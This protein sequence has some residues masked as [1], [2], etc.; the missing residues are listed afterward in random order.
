VIPVGELRANCYFL[1]DESTS[2]AMLIDPGADPDR[3]LSLVQRHPVTIRYIVNTHAHYDHIGANRPI[4]AATHAPILMHALELPMIEITKAWGVV[5]SPLP[6]QELR[7]GDVLSVGSLSF[8]IWHTP[9][10]SAGGIS[11]VGDG[12]VF[13]GDTLFAGDVGRY[14]LPGS[15]K[16]A[17]KE[18]LKHL[19]T[20]PDETI[21]YPG[22]GPKTTIGAERRIRV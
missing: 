18:S 3:I 5:D 22:H 12:L 13:T 20:L 15:S 19:M 4:Q 10:H 16:D 2:D 1:V 14:D 8:L 21:V 9:G 6:D 17:L 11:L 7:D